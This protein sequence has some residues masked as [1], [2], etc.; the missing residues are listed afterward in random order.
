MPI[1][2]ARTHVHAH[3]VGCRRP[4]RSLSYILRRKAGAC[5]VM[6]ALILLIAPSPY[7]IEMPGVTRNVLGNDEG[8]PIIS[9]TGAPTHDDSGK[10]LMLTVVTTGIPG[11]ATPTAAALG[12]WFV[13][14]ASA[15][16]VEAVIPPG[17]TVQE[18][19]QETTQE[20]T[21]SQDSSSVAALRYAR[22]HLGIDTSNI[23]VSM[24]IND[25]G[26]PSAGMM[27]SLGV[28]DKLTAE[29]ETGGHTIAGTGTMSNNGKV[30]AIGGIR[31][32]MIAAQR[33]GATW[34]LAPAS[35]CDEVVGHVP[36]GLRDV[37]VATL[38]DAYQALV[39]IGKGEGNALPHCTI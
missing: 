39:S 26:G 34:F 30:G 2:H 4:Q 8:T 22:T 20:M 10:L 37:R 27:Y 38:D 21:S 14:W 35:N 28:L 23:K 11:Y 9:I 5:A 29:D 31:L 18:Y 13:R 24:H 33:D 15:L 12:S 19:Q 7:A 17:Q 1:M 32:K 6:L 3:G 16:P 36:Q 25:I